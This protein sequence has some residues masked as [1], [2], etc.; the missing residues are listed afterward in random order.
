MNICQCHTFNECIAALKAAVEIFERTPRNIAVSRKRNWTMLLFELREFFQTA[1][2]LSYFNSF[3]TIKALRSKGVLKGHEQPSSDQ[4]CRHF[5]NE[6]GNVSFRKKW[7]FIRKE[8]LSPLNRWG[9]AQRF[10]KN[11][12]VLECAIHYLE[13]GGLERFWAAH[14]EFMRQEQPELSFEED[15]TEENIAAA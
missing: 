14:P 2:M 12:D 15:L 10:G 11:P 6:G 13:I 1:E 5:M 9:A 4:L 8:V 7:P 3:C